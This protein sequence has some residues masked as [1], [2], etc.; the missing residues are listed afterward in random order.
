MRALFG[1]T[2]VKPLN[3]RCL[4]GLAPSS[5]ADAAAIRGS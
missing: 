5:P 1:L 3:N 2:L 4:A